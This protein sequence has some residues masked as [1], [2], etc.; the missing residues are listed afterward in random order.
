MRLLLLMY[1][2]LPIGIASSFDE[3]DTK[4]PAFVVTIEKDIIDFV[5]FHDEEVDDDDDV[6]EVEEETNDTSNDTTSQQQQLTQLQQQPQTI[7]YD[8]YY[9][10]EV[11]SYYQS[12]DCVDHRS[13]CYSK[14]HLCLST[15]NTS[16]TG[17]GT[18]S[19]NDNDD[20]TTVSR[21]STHLHL[22]HHHQHQHQHHIQN[23]MFALCPRTCNVCFTHQIITN[24]PK[25][26]TMKQILYQQVKHL[27]YTNAQQHLDNME[28][29][30]IITPN[31]DVDTI[32]DA[33]TGS[34]NDD[35][36]VRIATTS[37]STHTSSTSLDSVTSTTDNTGSSSIVTTSAT[38]AIGVQF[39]MSSTT[40]L[41]GGITIQQR[42]QMI[43]HIQ[44]THQYYTRTVIPLLKMITIQ[45]T[46]T[47]EHEYGTYKDHHPNNNTTETTTT[48]FS[49]ISSCMNKSPYCTYWA[50]VH[51][52]CNDSFYDSVMIQHCPV[53]CQV[54]HVLL[55]PILLNAT[56]TDEQTGTDAHIHKE[57]QMMHTTS[58][59]NIDV[60][61]DNSG[62]IRHDTSS[63]TTNTITSNSTKLIFDSD[64]CLYDPEYMPN[65]WYPNTHVNQMFQRII[66]QYNSTNEAN[67]SITILSQ[68]TW[69]QTDNNITNNNSHTNSNHASPYVIQI[70]NFLSNIECDYLMQL[71]HTLGYERSMGIEYNKKKDNTLPTDEH[72]NNRHQRQFNQVIS[73]DRTSS[74]TWCHYTNCVENNTMIQFI[75][76]KVHELIHIPSTHYESLQLLQYQSGEYYKVRT[77]FIPCFQLFPK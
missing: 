32:R 46:T 39:L 22:H 49:N 59:G 73:K 45:N 34:G 44:Q 5:D 64:T 70:D 27:S 9:D 26:Q 50:I 4:D 7:F 23:R 19:D 47:S 2:I 29:H 55:Q 31:V 67:T 61:L 1:L 14:R 72:D 56:A 68:P 75:Y 13:Y 76:D 77:F 33:M 21:E 54:C 41:H 17:T 48:T 30:S 74:T 40:T 8:E 20:L 69:N 63:A 25:Q 24:I 15:G 10:N 18:G 52:R 62:D 28:Y 58:T 71:G 53:S 38:E 51:D 60:V 37:S 3:D 16:S 42:N 65:I 35:H 36:K 11:T 43:Q 57:E 12:R 6:E 66:S